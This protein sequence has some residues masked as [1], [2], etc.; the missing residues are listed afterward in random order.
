MTVCDIV[1]NNII[2]LFTWEQY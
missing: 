2:T 1:Q